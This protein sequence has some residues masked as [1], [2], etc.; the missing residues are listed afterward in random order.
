MIKTLNTPGRSLHN[1]RFKDKAFT[2]KFIRSQIEKSTGIPYLQIVNEYAELRRY[3]LAL[4]FVTTTNKAIC[5]AMHIP[6]EA[7]TKYKRRLERVGLLVTS[8][9]EFR[10]PYTGDL[11]HILSTN[12]EEFERLQKSKVKQLRIFEN[13]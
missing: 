3:R 1:R 11:A 5:E 8:I 7:G 10:C 12:P 9:D 2:L 6:V 13:E 4:S